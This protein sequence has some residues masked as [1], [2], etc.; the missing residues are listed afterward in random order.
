MIRKMKVQRQGHKNPI[1]ESHCLFLI[2][3]PESV[4]NEMGKARQSA[5]KFP[6]HG[7]PQE[8][9]S[10][11]AK[12]I[13]ESHKEFWGECFEH[14]IICFFVVNKDGPTTFEFDNEVEYTAEQLKMIM[15]KASAAKRRCVFA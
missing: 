4:V 2:Y 14:K 13:Y 3:D 1:P 10:R 8:F 7:N 5:E 9:Y 6:A 12:E 11:L 15:R